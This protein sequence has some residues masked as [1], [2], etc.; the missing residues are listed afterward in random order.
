MRADAESL[1]VRLCGCDF[2]CDHAAAWTSDN[3]GRLV[4]AVRDET[5]VNRYRFGTGSA[6]FLVCRDCGVVPIAISRIDDRDYAVVNT[7]TL[8]EHKSML[9]DRSV[10][11][12]D[13]EAIADRL[14][15]RKRNWIADVSFVDEL[16]G[17]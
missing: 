3:T 15:R 14:A 6:D 16:E 11:D 10:S 17:A 5:G 2:C 12:F 8:G 4:V 13:G 1:P 7:N 9:F